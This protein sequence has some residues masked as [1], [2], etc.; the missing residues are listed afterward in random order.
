MSAYMF[1]S[2]LARTSPVLNLSPE[3]EVGNIRESG[4]RLEKWKNAWTKW[5]NACMGG[6]LQI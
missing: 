1:L 2:L 5:G 3:K 4:E 6:L